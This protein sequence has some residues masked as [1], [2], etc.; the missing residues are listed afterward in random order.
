VR[1]AMWPARRSR[2]AGEKTSQAVCFLTE[3]A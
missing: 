2:P 3:I 1:Q